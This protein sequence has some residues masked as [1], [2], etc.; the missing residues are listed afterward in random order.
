V[1]LSEW[2]NV[3]SAN[4]NRSRG[5]HEFTITPETYPHTR[6]T[7][8]PNHRTASRLPFVIGQPDHAG[9]SRWAACSAMEE[10]DDPAGDFVLSLLSGLRQCHSA[11]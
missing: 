7:L 8:N 4:E 11:D 3:A 2:Q 1:A 9:P 5:K 10:I 6:P